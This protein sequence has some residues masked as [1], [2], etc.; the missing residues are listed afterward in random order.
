MKFKTPVVL[1][2]LWT[3]SGLAG[4]DIL[5]VTLDMSGVGQFLGSSG[6]LAVFALDGTAVIPQ[7]GFA[8]LF[9]GTDFVLPPS[10]SSDPFAGTSTFYRDQI[11]WMV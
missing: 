7:L 2:C 1:L 9:S 5:P 8:G 11:S 10:T 6:H 4:A 3:G